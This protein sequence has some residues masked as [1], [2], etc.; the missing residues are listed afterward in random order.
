MAVLRGARHQAPCDGTRAGGRPGVLLARMP[1]RLRRAR[2][3]SQPRRRAEV[4]RASCPTAPPTSRVVA[5]CSDRCP[6]RWSRPPSAS[7]IQ[8][9]W[10]PPSRLGGARSTRRPSARRAHA[11]QSAQ[12]GARHR[13]R[14]RRTRARDGI[15]RRRRRTAAARGQTALRRPARASACPVTR[16]AT[17]GGWPTMVREYRGDAHIGG[18]DVGRARRHRGRPPDRALL[19]PA[20]AHLHPHARLVRRRSSTPARIASRQRGLIAGDALTDA[21]RALRESV[22]GATDAQ[23]A[24]ITRDSRRRARRT[25]RPPCPLG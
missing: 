23:C 8:R 10:C 16:S 7:S 24:I 4:G 13:P 1:C 20:H 6:A 2:V 18:V 25:A 22:E 14:A 21:G 17:C 11:A 15:T 12:L 5:R 19:G 3:L 9:P